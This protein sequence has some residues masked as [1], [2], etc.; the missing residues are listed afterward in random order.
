MTAG[1][2]LYEGQS[3]LGGIVG[4]SKDHKYAYMPAWKKQIGRAHV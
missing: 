4:V 3:S 1:Y 2:G